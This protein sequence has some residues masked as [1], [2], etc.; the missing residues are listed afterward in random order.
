MIMEN[1][2]LLLLS[3]TYWNA[4]PLTDKSRISS[5]ETPSYH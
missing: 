1:D 5:W 4:G 3:R 2:Y